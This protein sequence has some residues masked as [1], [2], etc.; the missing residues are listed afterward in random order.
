MVV[1]NAYTMRLE[2]AM[3]A[4]TSC[5]CAITAPTIDF[6]IGKYK[7]SNYLRSSSEEVRRHFLSKKGETVTGGG[8]QPMDLLLHSR[9]WN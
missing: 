5:L 4:M 6:N 8:R 2:I 1:G 3:A 7:V 9:K